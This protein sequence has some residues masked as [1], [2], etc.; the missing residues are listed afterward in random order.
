VKHRAPVA[1]GLL[2]AAAGLGDLLRAGPTPIAPPPIFVPAAPQGFGDRQN[3]VAWAMTWWEKQRKLFVGTARATGCTA[4]A[5]VGLGDSPFAQYPPADSAIECT[6]DAR[7]LPLRAEIWTWSPDTGAWDLVFR[8]PADLEIPAYPGKFVARDIG[9]RDLTVF[10]EPDG[11][12]A[13]YASGVSSRSL[14]EESL[15]RYATDPQLPP[16]RLLRSVDGLDF[17]PTPQDPGTIWHRQLPLNGF[18]S[19]LAYRERLYVI[20]STAALGQGFLFE[21]SDP[22]RGND[23]FRKIQ[24]TPADL[25]LFEL[26]TYQGFLYVGTGGDPVGDWPPFSVWKTDASGPLPYTFTQVIPPGAF[27]PGRDAAAAISMFEYR[28]RLYVGTER[29]L[30]R[31]NPDDTWDLVVGAARDTP[32]GRMTP[33]SGQD[34]GFG[35]PFNIHM[36]RMGAHHGWLYVG[37]QDTS[38]NFHDAGLTGALLAPEMGFDL[39]RSDDGWYFTRLTRTGLADPADRALNQG[40]RTLTT[41]PYGFFLGGANHFFG[42]NIWKLDEATPR[43]PGPRRLE[44]ELDGDT[45]VLSWEGPTGA[46][47]FQVFRDVPTSP[48]R[49]VAID[50][51]AELEGTWAVVERVR[52]P[53][54]SRY[55]VVAQ[56]PTGELTDPSNLVAV[57]SQTPPVVFGEVE[58]R[59]LRWSAPRAWWLDVRQARLLA[60]LGATANA[61]RRLAGLAREV[62]LAAASS[63]EMPPWRAED[64]QMLLA[65]LIRRLTLVEMGALP[66]QA[67]F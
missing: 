6:P 2:A 49:R 40:A 54:S 44:A 64:V 15:E 13:L 56:S 10:T 66:K 1:L 9:F 34:D 48:T 42:A 3:S 55:H 8:S 20:A 36:W 53:R 5:A 57:P 63:R 23:A 51:P 19:L 52:D 21:A 43:R 41:T 22:A 29:E 26:A 31:V 17:E 25:Q 39:V 62:G 30:F 38:V 33:L 16:P 12:E 65:K 11:T 58:N 24:V 14:N 61:R 45:L 37:T 47:E 18:R 7:D 67:L 59:L 32:Q 46:A 60:Q 35:N 27:R 28:G 50:A 4:A